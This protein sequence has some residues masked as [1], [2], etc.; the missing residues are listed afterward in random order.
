MGHPENFLSDLAISVYSIEGGGYLGLLGKTR[1][2]T[3]GEESRKN[4][5]YS[6]RREP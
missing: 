6:R 2:K 4:H 5:Q 3:S 1:G